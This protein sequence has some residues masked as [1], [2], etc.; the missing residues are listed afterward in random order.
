MTLCFDCGMKCRVVIRTGLMLLALSFVT[1]AAWAQRGDV[2]SEL[3]SHAPYVPGETW[4]AKPET[5][6]VASPNFG[7]RS[8][9]SVIDSIVIHTTEVDLQ[10]T[11]DIFRNPAAQV[12]AHFVIASD[13]EV[14]EMVDS[15]F[16]A[17][18]ATYYNSRS[19][20]IEMV[21]YAGQPGTWNESNLASLAE[22]VAWITLAYPE[23]PLVHPLGDAYGYSNNT[24][25]E[26]GLVGHG[27][28]QPWN[29]T[30]PGV[31]FP[32][33][34]LLADVQAIHTVP[35]PGGLAL[36]MALGAFTFRRS[37]RGV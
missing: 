6:V 33:E 36:L 16:R 11:L 8:S 19:V 34:G 28:V 2:S 29:R 7:D 17:W 23:V 26:A 18:H 5:T 25:D 9:G 20:G 10:G 27:Q 32:W 21:G 4:L 30:D 13:G 31:Y 37:A 35:E 15:S 3:G 24:Y 12:S 14:F 22:V 1:Q